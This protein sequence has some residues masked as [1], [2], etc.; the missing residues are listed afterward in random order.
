LNGFIY[1]FFGGL[2][3]LRAR[4]IKPGFFDDEDLHLKLGPYHALLFAGLWCLADKQGKCEDRPIRIKANIL[5]YYD[6]DVEKLLSELEK[7]KF[8]TRYSL[9]GFK[10]LKVLNF[11]K[12]QHPHHTEKDSNIPD[13][14]STKKINRKRTVNRKLTNGYA[15]SDLLIPDSLI[16]DSLIPDSVKEGFEKFWNSYPNKKSKGY[17]RK[18][19]IK[20]K[21][22][23][24]LL[25]K[26]IHKIE[27]LKETDSWQKDG[28]K[29][30]PHPSTWLN[31]EGWEDEPIK[32]SKHHGLKKWAE[33]IMEEENE[34]N[35]SKT[36]LNPNGNA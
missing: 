21:P 32:V 23:D 8:I 17:A 33:E 19:W 9:N 10:Y 34:R 1:I 12:H 30:I 14:P 29:F 24:S 22:D 18:V 28:G 20:I 25:K 5:P 3:N 15:P 16:P 36:I 11:N 7:E 2:S 35:R 13:P 31:G 6:I 27:I 4:N 26:I